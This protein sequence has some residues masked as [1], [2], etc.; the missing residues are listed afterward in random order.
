MS[1]L[2]QLLLGFPLVVLTAVLVVVILYWLLVILG[3]LDVEVLDLRG[4]DEVLDGVLDAGGGEPGA[5]AA[6]AGEGGEAPRGAGGLAGLLT[7]LGLSGVPLTISLSAVVFFTWLLTLLALLVLR[8][9]L[10]S[11]AVGPLLGGLVVALAFVLALVV[12]GLTVVRPLR[13][14]FL[15]AQAPHRHD[16]VGR[17]CTIVSTRVDAQSGR[18]E[19]EDGG[20]GLLAEVRCFAPNTLTRGSR[21]VVFHY[22]RRAE[23]YHVVPADPLL[24]PAGDAP[25]RDRQGDLR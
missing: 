5:A 17:A 12:A 23:L 14:A 20:A 13:P 3:A 10:P 24:E 21:A 22:D 1:D 16:A 18:A 2:L 6:D 8:G 15:T 19:I 25:A 11:L 7:A 4:V 9:V